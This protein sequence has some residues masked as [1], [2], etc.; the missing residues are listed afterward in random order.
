MLFSKPDDVKYWG[1]WCRPLPV[2]I[3]L[4]FK[5]FL[6]SLSKIA[7]SDH[8]LT[9]HRLYLEF[10]F[11]NKVKETGHREAPT[12]EGQDSTPCRA[13]RV[14]P[15]FLHGT[16]AFQPRIVDKVTM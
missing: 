3:F 7:L 5:D 12:E 10:N 13:P 16:C 9:S 1:A 14:L 2:E 4:H 15:A 11:M 6:A 8:T